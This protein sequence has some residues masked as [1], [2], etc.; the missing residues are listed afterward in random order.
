M[1][2]GQSLG[3]VVARARASCATTRRL[4]HS[5]GVSCWYS[6][7]SSPAAGCEKRRRRV[8]KPDTSCSGHHAAKSALSAVSNS[9]SSFI[10]S[11]CRTVDVAASEL[12]EGLP[13]V[14]VP[15][16]DQ[17]ARRFVGEQH[18]QQ[19]A[20][21]GIEVDDARVQAGLCRVPGDELPVRAEHVRRAPASGVEQANQRGRRFARR[22]DR[23]RSGIGQ[24][25]E[26]ILAGV[27]E[28]QRP[29]DREEHVVGGIDAPALFE[30]RVPR[31]RHARE[32]RDFLTPETGCPATSSGGE[33]DLFGLCRLAPGAQEV[34]QL[35]S[36]VG[37]AH[38]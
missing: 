11:S 23:R 37:F 36:M 12:G 19:V 7:V 24:R 29:P 20:T 18:P 22:V 6:K 3:R 33:A 27:V 4:G 35:T 30:P 31:D 34:G 13:C 21:R 1:L 28:A 5:A 16:D 26:M 2:D 32:Q 15:V 8:S 14:D 25:D 9:T 38:A 10:A 17:L